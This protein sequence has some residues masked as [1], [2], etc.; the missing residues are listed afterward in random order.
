[1]ARSP[2]QLPLSAVH[3]GVGV[4]VLTYALP[5]DGEAVYDHGVVQTPSRQQIMHTHIMRVSCMHTR[6]TAQNV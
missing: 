3:G 4:T 1:V 6:M 2:L 5:V